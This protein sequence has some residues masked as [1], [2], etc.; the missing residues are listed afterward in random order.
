MSNKVI[1]NKIFIV[2]GMN[3]IHRFLY[4]SWPNG[5]IDNVEDLRIIKKATLS[6]SRFVDQWNPNCIMAVFD[7]SNSRSKRCELFPNYKSKRKRNEEFEIQKN[8]FIEILKTLPIKVIRKKDLEADDI[9]ASICYNEYK[10]NEINIV[11]TDRD[12]LQLVQ[13]KPSNIKLYDPIKNIFVQ[14]PKESS[15]ILKALTGDSSDNIPSV[16]GEVTAKKLINGEL[17]WESWMSQGNTKT[18]NL[19]REYVFNRNLK[20]ISLI[21]ETRA[22]PLPKVD[23]PFDVEIKF[24]ISKLTNRFSELNYV[25]PFEPNEIIE[26]ESIWN[27][28]VGRN[29]FS[30]KVKWPI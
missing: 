5:H 24:E 10:G 8:I 3:F 27:T 12:F 21:G 6:F 22:F 1:K 14:P 30:S 26:I 29:R 9:I 13:A 28:W 17:N 23:N 18:E 25:S 2:D 7:G 19:P 4:T 11:S 15:L 20:L 16:T